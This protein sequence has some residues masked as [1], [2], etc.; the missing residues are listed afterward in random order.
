[1]KMIHPIFIMFRLSPLGRKHGPSF[2]QILN[3]ITQGCSVLNLVEIDTVVLEK[4]KT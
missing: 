3:P 1:M 4:M 2:T